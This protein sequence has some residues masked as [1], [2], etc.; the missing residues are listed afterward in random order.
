MLYHYVAWY[1]VNCPQDSA[2]LRNVALVT[3]FGWLGVPLFFIISGFVIL[4]SALHRSP[5]QFAIARFIRLYPMYWVCLAITL[6]VVLVASQI[7]GERLVLPTYGLPT[8]LVN[9]TMLQEPMGFRSIDGVYW[10]LFKELQFYVLMSFL[11]VL[12]V[13]KHVR[14][15]LTVWLLLTCSFFVFDQPSFLGR[16]ISPEYSPFFIAGV[17]FSRIRTNGCNWYNCSVAGV[18]FALACWSMGE[19]APEFLAITRSHY[20]A[21]AHGH[22]LVCRLGVAAFF[23]VFMLVATRR[24][25]IKYSSAI[26]TLGMM[27]Y[28]LYLLHNY[29]GKAIMNTLLPV[30]S[31]EILIVVM[32]CLSIVA[33]YFA[34]Q[35]AD[36]PMTKWLQERLGTHSGN[37]S[38][39]QTQPRLIKCPP[40]KR[41]ILWNRPSQACQVPATSTS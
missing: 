36:K 1:T 32:S 18:A 17:T 21:T 12:G 34:Y 37:T 7:A 26:A 39:R 19:T 24:L 6:A 40:V 13:V 33:S 9:F 20:L 5:G 27:T 8:T 30:V 29:I 14:W 16:I 4:N 28:P 11:I 15:W 3:Q 31:A 38:H 2:V 41:V 25:S 10:T 22:V 35:Y 23:L